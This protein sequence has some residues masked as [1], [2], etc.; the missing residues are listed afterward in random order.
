MENKHEILKSELIKLISN[1]EHQNIDNDEKINKDFN[2]AL[3]WGYIE[4]K[5]I[6]SLLIGYYNEI[7]NA[8]DLENVKKIDAVEYLKFI[9]DNQT[10]N[11]LGIDFYQHTTIQ[12]RKAKVLQE[13]INSLKY[14]LKFKLK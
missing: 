11:L 5:G 12:I 6:N 2:N 7:I 13:Q 1:L 9:I 4:N 8:L 10:E 14:I 3:Y